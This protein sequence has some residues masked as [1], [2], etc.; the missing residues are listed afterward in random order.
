[1]IELKLPQLGKELLDKMQEFGQIQTIPAHTVIVRE[2][3]YLKVLPIVVSGSVK[4]YIRSETKEF[5]LYH[6]QPSE[7]CIMSFSSILFDHPSRIYASTEENSTLLLLPIE[8]VKE[9]NRTYPQLNNLFLRLFN[10][11]YQD[12]VNT[13]S[14]V[15]FQDLPTRLY[16][17]LNEKSNLQ[18]DKP[19]KI[20]HKTMADDLA[21]S[22]EV[23][24]RI[25]KKWEID[26]KIRQTK[27]EI[28][29]LK[30]IF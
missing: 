18:L 3:Q 21:S 9:W 8:K 12:L 7:S 6:I 25:L 4:V 29:I 24:S 10:L 11:R 15:L 1:M 22:R 13:I 14:D 28:T 16:H 5:L 17:Y 20:T 19:I 27:G 26:G 30:H 23:I 2:S